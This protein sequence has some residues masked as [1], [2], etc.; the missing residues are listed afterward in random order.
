ME[1]R[2]LTP[3]Q[4]RMLMFIL[5]YLA[6]YHRGPLIREV[7]EGCGIAS[8]KSTVDRINALERKGLLRRLPHK[9]RGIRVG[10]RTFEQFKPLVD[11][12]VPQ[13]PA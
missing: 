8:Y 4:A 2:T 5:R 11:G 10:R 3:R 7:Q 13:V 12:S 1:P 6:E 9:H